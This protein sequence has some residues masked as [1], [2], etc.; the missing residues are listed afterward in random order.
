[1]FCLEIKLIDNVSFTLN[2]RIFL[3][4]YDVH[5]TTCMVAVHQQLSCLQID[6]TCF[7]VLF[8]GNIGH[9]HLVKSIQTLVSNVMIA[10][11]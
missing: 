3:F 6:A 10:L 7:L 5:V 8:Q 11:R 1:M 4:E 2:I 9:V